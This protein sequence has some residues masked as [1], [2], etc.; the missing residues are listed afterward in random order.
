MIVK[1][2]TIHKRICYNNIKLTDGA[3]T[4]DKERGLSRWKKESGLISLKNYRQ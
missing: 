1:I 3:V 4:L 2:R